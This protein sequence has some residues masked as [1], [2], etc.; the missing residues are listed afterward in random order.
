M[1]KFQDLTGQKFALLTVEKLACKN[2]GR[3]KWLC[4]CDC[5]NAKVIRAE[6]LRSN[7]TKSCGCLQVPYGENNPNYRHG[8]RH[9]AEYWPWQ[10]MKDRCYNKNNLGY[11]YWGGRGITVCDRWRDSFENFIADMKERPSPKHSIDRIDNDKGYSP[12]NCRWATAL[13]QAR[14]KRP[15]KQTGEQAV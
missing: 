12:E 14:N 6:H 13:E 15:R 9:S 3:P 1:P 7:A 8:K 2:E 11:K 5:G 10:A 4:K